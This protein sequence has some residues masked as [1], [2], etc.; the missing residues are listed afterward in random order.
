MPQMKRPAAT[1]GRLLRKGRTD[2]P[3]AEPLPKGHENQEE[4]EEPSKERRAAEGQIGAHG[5]VSLMGSSLLH[6]CWYD[7]TLQSTL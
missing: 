6:L 2:G 5:V 7:Y 1:G 3:D 4:T